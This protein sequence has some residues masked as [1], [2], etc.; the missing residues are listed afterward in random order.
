M[1]HPSTPRKLATC[2]SALGQSSKAY[3][4]DE[5]SDDEQSDASPVPSNTGRPN[6]FGIAGEEEVF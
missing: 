1:S 3:R 2:R 4:R 5:Q 6:K